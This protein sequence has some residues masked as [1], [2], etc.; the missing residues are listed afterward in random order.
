MNPVVFPRYILLPIQEP[1]GCKSYG[2]FSFDQNRN[3]FWQRH[4]WYCL[5]SSTEIN[6]SIMPLLPR[7]AEIF[8]PLY[9]IHACL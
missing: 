8:Y 7:S 1:T 6:L 3:K 4:A 2:V 5:S 9:L